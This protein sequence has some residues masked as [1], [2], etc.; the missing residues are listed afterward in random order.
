MLNLIEF[1]V[2]CRIPISLNSFKIHLASG[3]PNSPKEA[4]FE[5]KFKEWQEWQTRRNFSCDM[6]VSLIDL[7]ASK[8]LFAG[9]YKVLGYEKKSEKHIAYTTELI[10]GEGDILGRIVV[11]HKRKGRASYLWGKPIN[12]EFEICEIREKK[13]TVDEFPGYNSVLISFSE[14]RII[15]NQNIQSWRGAL[16]NI[17]GVYLITDTASGKLYV[18]KAIGNDGIW[19]RWSN[20]IFTGHG[21]NIEL[22]SLLIAEGNDYKMNF[23]FSILEIADFHASD[24]YIDKREIYWKDVLQTRKFGYN[25]N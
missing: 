5:G 6:V 14:L 3:Y 20:Y 7:G 24:D 23:Q 12:K 19:N 4:F 2:A 22:K 17:K 21:G 13:L 8:W 9:V 1:L 16:S 25:S 10:E 18:G 15:I 11:Y